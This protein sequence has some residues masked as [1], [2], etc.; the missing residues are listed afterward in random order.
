MPSSG[1][2]LDALARL[3]VIQQVTEVG[4]LALDPDQTLQEV[5]ERIRSGL[6]ASAAT[7][8]LVEP[9]QDALVVRASAGLE[10][11]IKTGMGIPLGVGITGTVAVTRTPVLIPD[12]DAAA[13]VSPWLRASSQRCIV[14]VPLTAAGSVLGVLHA[15]SDRPNAFSE[16]DLSL[17]VML[18]DRVALAVERVRNAERERAAAAALRASEERARAVLETAVDGIITIDRAG[19]V[20]SMNPAAERLFGYS[21]SEVVGRKVNILMP[22]PYRSEHDEYMAR[23]HRTGQAR[24]IGIGRE[25]VG[26]RRDGSTFPLDL[27]VSEVGTEAG[28]YTGVVRDITE[29][30]EFEARLA[31]QALHDP[32]TGIGNR[33]LL[34]ER[35]EHALARLDRHPGLLALLF[36]DLDRFKLVNDTLGHEAGDDLLV[37]TAARLRSTLRPEDLVVRLGGDEFVVLCEEFTDPAEVEGLAQR[38]V[39]VLNMPLCL[40]GREV[41]VSASVGVAV[42][43]SGDRS[44]ADLLRDADAA[45]YHSKQ[46][47][48]GRYTVFDDAV[49]TRTSDR[50]QLGSELHHALRRHELRACYQPIASLVTGAVVAV[51]ALLRWDHPD[52]GR[53]TPGA[54]LDVA[55]DTGLIVDFDAWMVGTACGDA[56]EMGREL[57]GPVGVWVNLSGRSL[58]DPALADVIAAALARSALDPQLL[59]LEITEGALMQNAAETVGILATLRELGVQLAID[60]FGTGFSSLAYLQRF[61]VQAL[62]VDRSFVGRVDLP[63]QEASG[64]TAIIRSVVSLAASLGLRTVAEGIE[65]AEQLAT[66]T[67]LGCDLGQG[68]FLGRPAVKDLVCEAARYGVI[69]PSAYADLAGLN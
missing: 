29:R 67:S 68:F 31:A 34:V 49:R 1:E 47:G 48:R 25:M 11:E 27:A 5:L 3:A 16:G 2:E 33:G 21:A 58:A 20:E 45:M 37:Q 59:T 38:V 6:K 7:I 19:I 60:D 57:G 65:T 39:Q 64:S 62:K 24:I 10:S 13:S 51:E 18:G 30:K 61:P 22:E 32:L 69:L 41:F 8:M 15:T 44:A 55:D 26:R 14:A 23:Y 43:D 50:L 35:L 42:C 40:D 46:L 66:A 17:M 63:G 54:F 53:L 4:L 36:V 28:L 9:D 56:V 12:I 52:R